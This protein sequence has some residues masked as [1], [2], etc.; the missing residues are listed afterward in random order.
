MDPLASRVARSLRRCGEMDITPDRRERT[1]REALHA[2]NNHV[3]VIAM[4]V[5][6]V[7]DDGAELAEHHLD[8][9]RAIVTRCD[10]LLRLTRE[11]RVRHLA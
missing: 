8:S 9:L 11:L 3:H 6:L 5:Q 7:L 10:E 1:E 2:L 4:A